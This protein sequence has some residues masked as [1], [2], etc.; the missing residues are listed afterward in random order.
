MNL[1]GGTSSPINQ[2]LRPL[3]LT[4]QLVIIAPVLL[5]GGG[6]RTGRASERCVV[7]LFVALV[8]APKRMVVIWWRRDKRAARARASERASTADNGAP[9]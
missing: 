4:L 7:L 3:H 9:E 2:P 6:A 8:P 1:V 5:F